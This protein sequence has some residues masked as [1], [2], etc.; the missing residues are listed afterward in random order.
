MSFNKT[1]LVTGARRGI[2]KGIV[3]ALLQQPATTV[4]AAVREFS[5]DTCKILDALP[6]AVESKLIIIKI[7]AAVHSDPAEAMAVL[8][9]DHHID[10]IDVVIANAGI[11]HSGKPV[12]QNSMDSITDHLLVN[13]L[14]PVSLLQA[15]AP[16][17]KASK[18]RSPI[19][20]AISSLVGSI[21]GMELL[22]DL[23]P[24]VSPY[25]G[26]K[27]ALNWFL[28]RVHFEEPWLIALAIHP[29]VVATDFLA[30]HDF[31]PS[32]DVPGP[33]RPI[34]VE[35]SVQGVLERVYSASRE[36]SG[37]FQSY[38]NHVLPW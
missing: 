31:T 8:Q 24:A 10:F 28:R 26:S 11:A 20:V 29:G 3:R 12:L 14:G 33:I 23:P 13:T 35:E 25:G 17:L 18:S 21:S 4:I 1:Y 9:R 16:F 22:A 37:T 27:A 2:G 38:E 6:K 32:D 19:F 36:T 5:P 7:D 15:T 34:S 30:Q